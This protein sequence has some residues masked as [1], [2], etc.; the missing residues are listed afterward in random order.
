M[1]N[2][3]PHLEVQGIK[4]KKVLKVIRSLPREL[5]VSQE[6]KEI[7]YIDSAL[8][9]CCK[10]TISQPFIVAYMTEKLELKPNDNVL[11]IGTGSGFQTGV[12]SQLVQEVYTV[13]IHNELSKQAQQTLSKLGLQSIKYKIGDGKKGWQEFAPFDKIIVTALAQEIPLDLINQLK[14]G[15]KM[16]LPLKVSENEDFLFLINKLENNKLEKKQLI[17]IRFVNLV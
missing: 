11:E 4:E 1:K 13:E 12:L 9:I 6:L 14:I 10:Q 15:G 16:I 3:Y 17:Q 7:A 5:F 8:P 2:H